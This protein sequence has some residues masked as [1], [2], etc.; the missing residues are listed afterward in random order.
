MQFNQNRGSAGGRDHQGRAQSGGSGQSGEDPRI[1]AFWDRYGQVLQNARIHEKRHIWFQRACERFIAWMQPTRLAQTQRQHVLDYLSYLDG[2]RLERWELEQASQALRYL[3]DGLIGLPWAKSWVAVTWSE[4]LPES[5]S[6][7]RGLELYWERIGRS[8][9]FRAARERFRPEVDRVVRA[10]RVRHYS[11]RTEQTYLE[12]A[13]RFLVFC[14]QIK[15]QEISGEHVRGFLDDL[16]V[17]GQVSAGTQN[18]ALNALVFFFREGLNRSLQGLGDFQ[19]AKTS[20]HLPVVLTPQE[21]QR[22]FAQLPPPWALPIKLLYG[23]GLRLMECLRLR[24]KDLDFER[25]QITVWL[26]K[27]GKDRVTF[28]PEQLIGDLQRHLAVVRRTFEADCAEGY[29]EVWINPSLARKYPQAPREWAWQWVFP[30]DRLAVDPRSGHVRRHHIHANSVQKA[31]KTALRLAH[32]TKPASCHSLR[33]SFA[34]HLLEKGYDIRTVQ[35]LLGHS[36]VSTTMIY[37]HVLNRPGVSA[38][39]PLDL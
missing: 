16:A 30:A 38:R 2:T 25:R 22:L 32:I 18:Q 4:D 8:E 9:A 5:E 12:W 36:D 1:K 10:F 19:R 13:Y 29:G 34:T 37:T 39:S 7:Q 11:Y 24:I 31:L 35:E 6:V 20:R 33:H 15:A 28:L 23:S 21:V 17:R 26:G 27:G 3:L 14:G